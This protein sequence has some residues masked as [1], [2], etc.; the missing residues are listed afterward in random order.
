MLLGQLM[1]MPVQ[2]SG[3]LYAVEL[4]AEYEFCSDWL[5]WYGE[6]FMR[7]RDYYEILGVDKHVDGN[8]IKKAY[9]NLAMKYH[10]DRNPGREKEANEK[11]KEINKAYEVLGDPEKRRQYDMFGTAATGDIFGSPFTRSGFEEVM[12]DFGKGGLGFDFLSSIFDGF[13]LFRRPGRMEFRTRR[14]DGKTFHG[15]IPLEDMLGDLFG[16]RAGGGRKRADV[17]FGDVYN[18]QNRDDDIHERLTISPEKARHGVKMEYKRGKGRIE[19]TIPAG[20]K[21]GERVRYKGARLKL[22]GKPGDL[23]VHVTVRD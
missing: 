7:K 20:V 10:P 23:Y 12:S 21:T 1:V 5:S 15:H 11:F 9:R 2:C 3:G 6:S 19:I 13:E 17:S 14:P 4:N 16:T 8:A 18:Q 22:D